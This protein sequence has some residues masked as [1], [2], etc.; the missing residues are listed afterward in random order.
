MG[1]SKSASLPSWKELMKNRLPKD[2]SSEHFYNFYCLSKEFRECLLGSV[3]KYHAIE[4]YINSMQYQL[5]FDFH[6]STNNCY[7][8]FLQISWDEVIYSAENSE[9]IVMPAIPAY[10]KP[11][12]F[13]TRRVVDT[14]VLLEILDV[15][16]R[17]VIEYQSKGMNPKKLA[18]FGE[19]S[20]KLPPVFVP[21]NK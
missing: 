21:E 2:A 4:S 19:F 14:I 12:L 20:C 13:R 15:N 16:N 17:Q 6:K 5:I 10:I 11:V 7:G 8:D 3:M 1:L 9:T 18:E